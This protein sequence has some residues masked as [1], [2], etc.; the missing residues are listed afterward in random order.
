MRAGFGRQ[1]LQSTLGFGER[2]WLPLLML[3]NN[4]GVTGEKEREAY[5]FINTFALMTL[6]SLRALV[7]FYGSS[8][9]R[10]FPNSMF[11]MT[12][13]IG[14]RRATELLN[15]LT[16]LW[17]ELIPEWCLQ[18][19]RKVRSSS[20]KTLQ[21]SHGAYISLTTPFNPISLSHS[22]DY[23]YFLL[24]CT[25]YFACVL[26]RICSWLSHETEARGERKKKSSSGS[27]QTW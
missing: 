26:C 12:V 27:N 5:Y 24:E 17:Y 13:V 18:K 14:N 7:I 11:L 9:T 1:I 22:S 3:S 25:N 8:E 10:Y 16:R 19:L 6:L 2:R 4:D 21:M 15:W 20:G 23:F